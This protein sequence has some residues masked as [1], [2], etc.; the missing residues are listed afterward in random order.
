MLWVWHLYLFTRFNFRWN[1]TP[2]WGRGQKI[3]LPLYA[4]PSP[5]KETLWFLLILP[6]EFSIFLSSWFRQ[7]KHV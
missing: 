2:L 6:A 5:S 4:A 1:E 7:S 3:L